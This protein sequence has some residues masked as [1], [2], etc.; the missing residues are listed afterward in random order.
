MLQAGGIGHVTHHVIRLHSNAY[1]V[2]SEKLSRA[3]EGLVHL[4]LPIGVAQRTQDA[5]GLVAGPERPAWVRV[6]VVQGDLRFVQRGLDPGQEV[7]AVGHAVSMLLAQ[8]LARGDSR[9]CRVGGQLVRADSGYSSTKVMR[10]PTHGAGARP[11]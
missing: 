8:R 11:G 9:V 1:D 3:S 6:A 2:Q 4:M 5:H 10:G 7:V